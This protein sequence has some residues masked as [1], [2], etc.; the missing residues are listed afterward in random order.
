MAET[1]SE[2]L[3]RIAT[4]HKEWLNKPWN[5]EHLGE[6]FCDE[7][8]KEMDDYIQKVKDNKERLDS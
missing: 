8:L 5:R 4:E 3:I 7:Q 2:K 6:D 1:L